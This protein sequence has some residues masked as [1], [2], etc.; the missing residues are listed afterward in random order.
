MSDKAEKG[1][2]RRI[3][4]A[5][6]RATSTEFNMVVHMRIVQHLNSAA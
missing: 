4:K 5:E 2:D 1:V 3:R 6:G